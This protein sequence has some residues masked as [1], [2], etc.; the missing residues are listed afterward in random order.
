MRTRILAI[1]FVPSLALFGIGV[2]YTIYLE[3]E[4]SHAEDFSRSMAG[5]LSF[6]K[7]LMAS[8]EDERLLSL[9][10][11][12]GQ[13][14]DP[15]ALAA[16]RARVDKALGGLGTTGRSMQRVGGSGMD[17]KVEAFNK[18]VTVQLPGLRAGVDAGAVQAPDVYGF[19]TAL[20]D[21]VDKGSKIVGQNAPTI[22]AAIGEMTSL[23]LFQAVEASS[24]ANALTAPASG[25]DLPPALMNEFRNNV[26][27][28]HSLLNQLVNDLDDADA[29][30]VK[31][32][33]ASPALAQVSA[34]EDALLHP[35]PTKNGAP[36]PLPMSLEEWRTAANSVSE[37]LFQVTIQ[38]NANSMTSAA[39]LA[40]S[41]SRAVL[42]SG[43][44]AI[45]LAIVAF[46]IAILLANRI[47]S[48]LRRLRTETL[49]LAEQ[50]L[51][52]T[53]RKIDAG[54]QVDPAA[55]A[56]HLDFGTDEIGEVAQAFNRAHTAA[57]SAAITE[58]RT[59]E[60]VRAVFLNIAH[61]SQIVVARQLELLD[62]AESRQEDP[63]LLDTFFRLDH[64]ATRERRNAE[65]LIIL[66][67]GKPGRQ[68]RRPVPLMELV[69]SA[70]A[71]TLDYARVNT[72]RLPRVFV[73]GNVV[74]DL[75]HLLAELVDNA[76]AFSPP[77]SR[78]DVT[79]NSVGKGVVVE[80]SDQGMGMPA[81]ELER[82]NEM[83]RNPPDFGLATLSADSRLGL[84][85][86]AQLATR[87]GISVRLTDSDYGGIRAIVLIPVSLITTDT[88]VADHLRDRVPVRYTATPPAA[89]TGSYPLPSLE[90]ASAAPA[91]APE[92]EPSEAL[93]VQDD[94]EF[95]FDRA[96]FDTGRHR[97]PASE[98]T[99]DPAPYE[100]S[101]YE[102]QTY[103][104]PAYE[105][106]AYERPAPQPADTSY[107]RPVS[108]PEPPPY[109]RQAPV[110]QP[111][112]AYLR[113]MSP[114]PQAEPEVRQT[115]PAPTAPPA[116]PGG[117]RP[118]LPR[119]RRQASLA[120]ELA[121]DPVAEDY[122]SEPSR[123]AEQARDLMS[124]IENGTRQ[125]R[126]AR[127][128]PYPTSANPVLPNEQEGEG[129]F[130]YRR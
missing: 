61:R 71:E 73:M 104:R 88:P 121:N 106:Q 56:A 30:I 44:S 109:T 33:L 103:E 82:V 118:P 67:G 126:R 11:L 63:A 8:V 48:R 120:P 35:A 115:R 1:A 43:G 58:A 10:Q 34:M 94:A 66:G 95:G 81:D 85:V 130:F 24:R 125:G 83:L 84:F 60:G 65:N 99:R 119:R 128:D 46:A 41:R 113:A 89:V 9:A 112:T 86:V 39:D 96:V 122:A 59:R 55:E 91:Y 7:E 25:G 75:M 105:P 72:H 127:P 23:K 14:S 29:K 42:V 80:I 52:E 21:G 92:P 47:I 101:A 3:D 13:D 93:A 54:E 97:I 64:L 70:V 6:T 77:Q 15:R 17:E 19:Y 4:A 16:A 49:A 27:L 78:V 38:Q 87:H 100:T 124:A 26:G 22:A 20:L 110:E 53:M 2:G 102:R 129:D 45:A 90:S 18:L 40:H 74:A 57:V 123:S 32:L 117:T 50:K 76:T 37:Q 98:D 28:Y 79:G 36:P 5:S 12:S 111:D 31:D 69:R 51:P 108:P 107:L 62:Q 116:G 68:W 114:P